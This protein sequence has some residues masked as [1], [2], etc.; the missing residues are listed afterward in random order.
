MDN[1]QIAKKPFDLNPKNGDNSMSK[2]DV[3]YV[4]GCENREQYQ[5]MIAIATS[6]CDTISFIYFKYMHNEC[7][8]ESTKAIKKALQKYKI[9]SKKVT[10]W[11]LTETRDYGH[12]YNLVTYNIPHDLPKTFIF[13][14][15][16]EAVNTLWDW[17]YPE[18]P[19]DPCFYRNGLVFFASCTHEQM[20]ELY[21]RSEGDYLSKKDFES[22]GLKL[23][24]LRSVSEDQL[25]HL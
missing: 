14:D 2:Y 12:I 7:S 6:F 18:Y 20:N 23:T 25:F 16:L 19:M 4:D 17:S 1:S 22:M 8:S 13:S 21:L 15:A 10:A 3:Y 9:G 5:K 24:Y 11:P